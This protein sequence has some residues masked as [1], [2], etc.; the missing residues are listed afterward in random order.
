MCKQLYRSLFCHQACL[1][2]DHCHQA[3]LY[4]HHCHQ[5][6]LYTHHCHQVCLYTDHCHQVCLYT[7]HC[8]QAC[9]LS[10]S[11]GGS[12]LPGENPPHCCWQPDLLSCRY[13]SL[14]SG[15]S[16]DN[17]Q[18]A[19]DRVARQTHKCRQRQHSQVDKYIQTARGSVAR[20]T[21]MQTRVSVHRQTR[22]LTLQRDTNGKVLFSYCGMLKA[23]HPGCL[24]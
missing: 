8:Y 15:Y 14:G 20:Q 21:Q 19:R 3:C 11:Q 2:T 7:H 9:L 24:L 10:V 5:V 6:C 4:T 16:T 12:L 18:I 1:Y 13:Q 17:M 22:I 23:P